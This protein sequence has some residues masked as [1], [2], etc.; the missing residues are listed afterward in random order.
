MVSSTDAANSHTISSASSSSYALKVMTVAA[1]V[2][3][4]V[5]L[6]YQGWT[7]HVFRERLGGEPEAAEVPEDTGPATHAEPA[8]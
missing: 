5:V 7:Y 2:L 8:V 3:V 4:P 1:L 6:L